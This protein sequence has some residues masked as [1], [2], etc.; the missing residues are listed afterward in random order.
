MSKKH[1]IRHDMSKADKFPVFDLE[2]LL[3]ISIVGGNNFPMVVGVV[4]RI[5]SDLLSLRRNTSIIISKR[6]SFSVTVK[7]YTGI[8]VFNRYDISIQNADRLLGHDVVG[9]SLLEF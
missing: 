5:S 8:L 2:S 4:V 9:Q 1:C 6:V 3:L 7:V